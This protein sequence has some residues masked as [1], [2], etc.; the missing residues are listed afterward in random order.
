MIKKLHFKIVVT[1][2]LLSTLT[3]FSQVGIGTTTPDTDAAL[4]INSATG[5]VLLPRVPLTDTTSPL[6]LS[7]DVAGMIVYNTATVSDV[8]PGFYY[9]DGAVWV[10]LGAG[11]A[12]SNDWALAGNNGTTYGTDFVGTTDATDLAISRNSTTKIRVENTTT[13][14]ANEIR[15]RD[16]STDAGDNLVRIYDSSDDGIIDV[17]RNNQVQHRLHGNG[18]TVFNERSANVDFRIESN[19]ATDGFFL[20]G[21]DGQVTIGNYGSGAITAGAATQMLAV[22]VNGNIVEEPLPAGGSTDWTVT[23]NAGLDGGTTAVIGTNF[24]GTTDNE[25]IE[26]RTNNIQ[27]ARLSAL[28]E[29]FVGT[30]NTVI[31]GDLMNAVGNATFPWA[32]NGYTSENGGGVYGSVQAGTT[33]F[34]AVQ[35]EYVG[36]GAI[37]SGVRGVQFSATP[38]TGF[39][40]AQTGVIGDVS[41]VGGTYKFGVYGSGGATRRTGGVMGYNFG[42]AQGALGYYA[43]NWNDYS[44]Y[45]FGIAY[46]TG[47]ATGRSSADV[48]THIGL[49]I[50]GGVIGGWVKG[51]EYGSI[52]SG[53]RFAN[54]NL[55]KTITNESFIVLDKK[56][57][58]TKSVSYASTSMN[59][60]IQ[61]KGM[62]KLSNGTKYVAFNRNYSEIIDDSK[63]IIVTVTTIGESNGV[64]LIS[65]DKNGFRIKENKNGNSN[66]SF[67]WIV[68]AEK[69]ATIE[70]VTTEILAA[71]FDNNLN[72]VMHNDNI[73]GGKAIWS[74]NGQ[75]KFGKTAP[76][77][78]AKDKTN[79][80]SKGTSRY[81]PKDNQKK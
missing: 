9:N 72:E 60:D 14:F 66:V 43:Q 73:D 16:G 56:Q 75:I 78:K 25:N 76:H 47:G 21:S 12:P 70:P 11:G 32:V 62:N 17:Y 28:G 35:G 45:G 3:S 55:G 52:S 18:T 77:I 19:T 7:A 71:D 36:T 42:V 59:V 27:R 31:A 34:A 20:E 69:N 24:L 51:Q 26:F 48:N 57:D 29:F 44:V 65:V 53:K 4:E 50:H 46:Q 38:G 79:P 49:G 1:I 5:G 2:G 37:G 6:P 67:N 23:G 41:G 64:H 10:R 39:G 15:T 22:D 68:I 54:Y 63:P 80:H 61:D 33:N 40:A 13:T 8:T 58:G 30:I 74:E 81:T